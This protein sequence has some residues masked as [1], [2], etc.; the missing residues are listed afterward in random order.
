MLLSP[1]DVHVVRVPKWIYCV[2]D[3]FSLRVQNR[4][5]SMRDC[6][7]PGP[8]V[9]LHQRTRVTG[10]ERRTQH[11]LPRRRGIGTDVVFQISKQIFA[12]IDRVFGETEIILFLVVLLEIT[13]VG[14][15]VVQQRII[16][17]IGRP[18][19]LEA[20]ILMHPIIWTDQVV[21]GNRVGIFVLHQFVL[22]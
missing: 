20:R 11:A 9:R 18:A 7:S 10:V 2:N 5:Q 13:V 4:L 8:Y 12:A 19:V 17:I 3:D 6:I 22:N 16:G 15:R 14:L 1:S 21:T